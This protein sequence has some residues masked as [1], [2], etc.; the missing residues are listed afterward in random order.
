MPESQLRAIVASL[1]NAKRNV[2]VVNWKTYAIYGKIAEIIAPTR[3]TEKSR[4]SFSKHIQ[5]I[6]IKS[7]YTTERLYNSIELR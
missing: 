5:M 7:S 2:R 6:K 4:S 1:G 3:S